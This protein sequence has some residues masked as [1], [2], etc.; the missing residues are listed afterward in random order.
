M[1]V[2][3][4]LATLGAATAWAD[5]V[6][7]GAKDVRTVFFLSP[8]DLTSRLDYGL[9]LDDKC[10]PVSDEPLFPYWHEPEAN[11]T[12][13]L[14]FF[15]YPAYGVQEQKIKKLPGRTELAVKLKAL[16]RQIV[17]TIEPSAEGRCNATART[18]IGAQTDVELLSVYI[19]VKPVWRVDFIEIRGRTADGKGLTERVAP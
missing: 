7:F 6:E 5:G 15:E 3:L 9:K 4:L 2:L 13:T 8:S 16:P 14:K 19:K 11:K 1:R 17:I 10:A 12:A 18:L